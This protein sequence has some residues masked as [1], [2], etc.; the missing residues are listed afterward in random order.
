MRMHAHKHT[1]S[2]MYMYTYTHT[3]THTHTQNTGIIVMVLVAMTAVCCFS[4]VGLCCGLNLPKAVKV[5]ALLGFILLA[6]GMAIYIGWLALGTYLISTM[7]GVNFVFQATCTGIIAYVVFM[8]MYILVL[9]GVI[10]ASCI[11]SVH[12]TTEDLAKKSRP[13]KQSKPKLPPGV[14]L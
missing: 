1:Y 14:G 4:F 8:F 10:I 11:W 7:G 13:S 3:H 12:G 6:L 5:L 2:Y 9:V